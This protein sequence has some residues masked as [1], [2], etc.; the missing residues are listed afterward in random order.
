MDKAK[1][2]FFIKLFI[3]F[4]I[5]PSTVA[6]G[7]FVFKEKGFPY[8]IT[9]VTVLTLVIFFTSFEKKKIT[10]RKLVLCAVMTCLSVVGRFIPFLKPVAALTAISGMYL[11]C[12]SGFLVGALSALISN[13]YFGQGPW[14]PHQMFAWGLIGFFSGVFAKT[15]E[16]HKLSLIIYGILSGIGYSLLLDVWTVLW[17]NGTFS[18]SLYTAAI[19]TS[20]PH[21]L[22]YTVSN[23]LFLILLYPSLGARLKRIKIK[24]GV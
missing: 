3:L 8:V 7:I 12:E 18:L 2:L 6:A 11:G 4:I 23:V 15:L 19:I 1:I 5:I 17:Y 21:T 13:F 22:L 9:A 24:Y 10:T 20:F 14:T 16:K